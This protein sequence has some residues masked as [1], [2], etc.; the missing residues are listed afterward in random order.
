M[1]VINVSKCSA[2]LFGKATRCDQRLSPVQFS[3]EPKQCFGSMGYTADS[4][5]PP[6]SVMSSPDLV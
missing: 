2:V 3:G 6:K 1:I 4:N 5:C